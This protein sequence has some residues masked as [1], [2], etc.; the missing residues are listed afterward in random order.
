MAPSMNP[1]QLK[2]IQYG[3]PA[4]DTHS[5]Y[6]EEEYV[7][8]SWAKFTAAL[9]A[10]KALLTDPNATGSQTTAAIEALNAAAEGLLKKVA[11]TELQAKITSVESTYVREDYTATSYGELTGAIRKAN[12]AITADDMSAADVA[13]HIAAIDAAVAKLVKRATFVEIDAVLEPF[14]NLED[15]DNI[16]ILKRN[17]TP[18]S[19]KNFMKAVNAI[20]DAKKET[21]KPNV[22]VDDEAKLLKALNEAI[23]QLVTYATYGDIDA[24]IEE[25]K[26]LDS[27][28]YT[29]ESWNAVQD[30][31]TAINNLKSNRDA[32]QPEADALLAQLNAAV[33][34]LVENTPAASSDATEAPAEEKKS[35]CKSVIG[36][37]V[38][39]MVATLGLG[40]TVVL[41]KKD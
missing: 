1:L 32:T 37:T 17:Y 2:R 5:N 18:D 27:T 19:W 22:S 4:I 9:D 8:A 33:D 15:E 31:I 3:T 41:K 29:T 39:V 25:I 30:A 12:E 36:T 34:A 13:A 14:G 38:V 20:L 6:V 23:A 35:G 10:A 24:R 40:A 7:T 28:K 16:E 26:A 11:P 21:K